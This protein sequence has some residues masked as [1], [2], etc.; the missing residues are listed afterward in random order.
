MQIS[1]NFFLL[2][3]IRQHLDKISN[4]FSKI[5]PI[6]WAFLT[7]M[8][9]GPGTENKEYWFMFPGLDKIIHISIFMLLAF[10]FMAALPRIKFSV[11]IQ[12][13]LIYA[14]LT[15]IL[16]LEMG[17]GRSLEFFDI[18]AD[19]AGVLLG[20]LLYHKIKSLPF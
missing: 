3:N 9:L 18:I 6:Y 20:Y 7:Y 4:I 5:L 2:K 19:T 12:V 14:F 13:M 17:F 8:L 1:Q 11:F 16:Q 15:E 10:C